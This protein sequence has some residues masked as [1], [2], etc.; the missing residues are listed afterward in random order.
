MVH[1]QAVSIGNPPRRVISS[2]QLALAIP[3]K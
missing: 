1:R 2:Q 3:V